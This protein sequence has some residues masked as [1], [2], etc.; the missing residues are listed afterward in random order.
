MTGSCT[1]AAIKIPNPETG[2]DMEE[3][4]EAQAVADTLSVPDSSWCSSVDGEEDK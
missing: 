4:P 1:A 3:L 2:G